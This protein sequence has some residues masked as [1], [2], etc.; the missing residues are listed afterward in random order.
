VCL[1]FRLLNSFVVFVV[2]RLASLGREVEKR[3]LNT[4][5]AHFDVAGRRIADEERAQG[6][7]RVVRGQK[8]GVPVVFDGPYARK[9]R[10]R[11]GVRPTPSAE[12]ISVAEP[13]ATTTPRAI[14][15][16]RSA[17]ESA[18]SR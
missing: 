18:S 4:G 12:V 15:T 17:K 2:D 5:A 10:E 11:G 8:D 16:I 14:T 3:L 1:L 13:S 9:P 7:V 6:G